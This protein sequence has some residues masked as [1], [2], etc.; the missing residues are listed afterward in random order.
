MPQ[1]SSICDGVPVWTPE[2]ACHEGC[3]I[4]SKVRHVLIPKGVC[5]TIEWGLRHPDGKTAD[6]SL[7]YSTNESLSFSAS[8][9]AE[10]MEPLIKVRI[11]DCDSSGTI[12]EVT[13]SVADEK[14]GTVRFALPQQVFNL[15][16]IYIMD[17]A[18]VDP[19]TEAPI[20]IDNG[21]LSVEAGLFGSTTQRTGPPTFSDIRIHLRDTAVEN[22]LLD[23][24]EFDTPEV[25]N[26]LVYPIHQWNEEP[27]PV[28][29]FTCRTFPFRYHWRQ[30][31][32]GELLRIAAH[33]YM[34]N[35]LKLNHGGLEGN[36][37][38][39]YKEYLVLAESYRTEW[40]EF[41]TRKKIEINA[42]MGSSSLG[43]TYSQ[44]QV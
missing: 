22:D 38:D 9:S 25:V 14:T 30:A 39:K 24:V 4:L 41:I 11:G 17:M 40:K 1:T 19:I 3:A 20:F 43:S 23:D 15:S 7:C 26:A 29:V 10:A 2:Q 44:S 37:K 6:L 28:A 8:E 12:Y 35:N 34:R 32:A 21:L 16:G 36:I 27:P 33:H 42:G 31:V 5:A 13:G 18:V